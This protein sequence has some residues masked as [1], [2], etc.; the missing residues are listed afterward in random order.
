MNI[1]V[2]IK[3]VPDTESLLE[4]AADGVSIKPGDVKWVVNP[5][6]E[7]AIEE[8]LRIREAQGQG[9]VTVVSAGSERVIT[10][11]RTALA[12]GAEDAILIQDPALERAD[13][14][15]VGRAL[16]GAIKDIPFDLILAGQRALDDDNYLVPAVLAETLGIPLIPMVTHQQ[17]SNHRICCKQTVQ[18]G[19]LVVETDLPAVMTTQR[20]LNEPRY[21]S[22]PNIM[23]AKKKTIAIRSLSDVGVSLPTESPVKILKLAFP[24]KRKS[25]RIIQGDSAAAKAAQLVRL[26]REEAGVPFHNR[27]KGE[28]S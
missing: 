11:L 15:T 10:A 6:D 4:I 1:I 18:G 13:S 25:G 17:I 2:L 23:K 3:Q 12:M 8:A 5:Y 21:A 24:P 22:M 20:G 16:A 28:K 27:A 9:K 19:R 26:L 7:L 14:F